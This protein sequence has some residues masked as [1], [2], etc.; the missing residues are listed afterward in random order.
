MLKMQQRGR[1]PERS[2]KRAKNGGVPRKSRSPS[3]NEIHLKCWQW[4]SK[5]RPDLLIFHVANERKASVQYH[6]KLKR[7]GVL[8]GTADFLAFPSDGRKFAIELKD[9]EGTQDSDQKKFQQR[10]ERSG[11]LYYVVRTLTEF[12]GIVNAIM[13]FA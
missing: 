12:Q 1:L 11:G 13:M 9:D 3:E 2:G 6:I 10:W 7:L 5:T 4:V 8:K